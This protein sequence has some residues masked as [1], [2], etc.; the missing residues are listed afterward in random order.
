LVVDKYERPLHPLVEEFV[1][2]QLEA[3]SSGE[4]V[5]DYPLP[6]LIDLLRRTKEGWGHQASTELPQITNKATKR[7]RFSTSHIARNPRKLPETELVCEDFQCMIENP[8]MGGVVRIHMDLQSKNTSYGGIMADTF[9][10][11]A[12]LITPRLSGNL[13]GARG[14][15][16]LDP[17]TQS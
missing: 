12:T 3:H 1:D 9:Q 6:P 2:N 5:D 14:N 17:E 8:P 13:F 16:A 15:W 10:G 4:A 7:E 11:A